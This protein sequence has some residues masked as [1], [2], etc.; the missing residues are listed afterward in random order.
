MIEPGELAANFQADA[1]VGPG[2]KDGHGGKYVVRT[3]NLE[4]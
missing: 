4:V 2:D 3:W 1:L